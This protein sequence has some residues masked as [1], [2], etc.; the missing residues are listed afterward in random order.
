MCSRPPCTRRHCTGILYVPFGDTVR[1]YVLVR[2]YVRTTHVRTYID[3]RGNCTIE[4]PFGDAAKAT[5]KICTWVFG[6][7]GVARS[8]MLLPS[9]NLLVAW[10]WRRW[11]K[12]RSH[13][14]PLGGRRWWLLRCHIWG[15]RWGWH[16]L[17]VRARSRPQKH[18]LVLVARRS[19]RKRRA[20]RGHRQAT[21]ARGKTRG[22]RVRL[23]S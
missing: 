20:R 22:N 13:V 23:A 17:I 3:S 21:K 8:L 5:W 11:R 6:N 10:S 18:I 1:T 15:R 19:R 12:A 4:T 2:T 16:I 7:T 9:P 14:R